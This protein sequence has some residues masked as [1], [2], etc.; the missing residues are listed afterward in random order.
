MSKT[1]VDSTKGTQE[2]FDALEEPIEA[3]DGTEW[4]EIEETVFNEL[5]EALPREQWDKQAIRMAVRL[6]KMEVYFDYLAQTLQEEGSVIQNDRGTP[7]SNPMHSAMTTTWSTVKMMRSTLG[8]TA[9]Q[10]TPERGK[11]QARK[12]AEKRI[13]DAKAAAKKKSKG[14]P[15]LLAV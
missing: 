8:I 11:Q 2:L 10:R 3:P 4:S 13:R 15:S 14:A 6:A 9:S 5:I 7:I 1:R 12:D